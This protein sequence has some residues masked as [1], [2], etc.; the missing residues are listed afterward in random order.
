MTSQIKC[1]NCGKL[2]EPSEA[3]KHELEEKLSKETELKHKEEVDQLK[4]EKQKLAEA[5]AKEIEAVKKKAA[6]EVKIEVQK[7]ISKDLKD[8]EDEVAQ[9]KNRAEKAEVEELKLRKGKRELEQAKEKFEVEKQRQLDEERDTIKKQATQTVEEKFNLIIAEKDKQNADM[10]K[11]LEEAQRKGSQTS[12]QLQGEVLELGFEKRLKDTF[13]N[14]NIEPVEK[15]VKGADVRQTVLSPR[16]INCGV[17]LWETKRTKV[18][19]GDWIEK[20]KHDL[21]AEKADIPVIVSTVMPKEF[22][23]PLGHKDGVEIVSFELAIPL[24]QLLRKRLLEVGFQKVA[25]AHK[26][27]KAEDLYNYIITG[28]EFRQQVEA[29]VETFFQMKNQ[30]VKERAAYERMW[31]EREKQADKLLNS[32]ANIAGSIQGEIGQGS[33]QIKGLELLELESGKKG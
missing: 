22:K 10:K 29:M 8:K 30:I 25:A 2:F 11:A 3:F 23:N 21:R 5:K 13:P 7:I 27:G 24:A 17:I 15:G 33:F 1:P 32:T 28:H 26:G 14:D 16:G 6:E 9:W 18:W 4:L 19:G 12:Q 20:L 31:Q